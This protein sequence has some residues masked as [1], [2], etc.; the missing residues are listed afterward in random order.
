MQ[1]VSEEF[2]F[3]FRVGFVEGCKGLVGLDPV[4]LLYVASFAAIVGAVSTV[5]AVVRLWR[6]YRLLDDKSFSILALGFGAYVVAL[7]LEAVGNLFFHPRGLGGSG[8]GRRPVE[9]AELIVNRGSLAALPIYN[10]AYTLMA[11]SHYVASIGFEE[12]SSV[13][14]LRERLYAVGVPIILLVYGDLNT[15]SF[16]ILLAAAYAVLARYG[17][18]GAGA[19]AFYALA[20]ASHLLPIV[21]VLAGGFDWWVIPVATVLRGLAPLVLLVVSLRVAGVRGRVEEEV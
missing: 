6:L 4:T 12:D 1:V 14:T 3:G 8:M 20:G 19:V 21:C 18:A 13:S 11:V 5:Y 7:L 17:R 9:I 15:L 16:L 10:V 2:Y